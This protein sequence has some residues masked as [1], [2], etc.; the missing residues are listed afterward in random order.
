[1]DVYQLAAILPDPSQVESIS[2]SERK[3]PSFQPLDNPDDYLSTPAIIR[4]ENKPKRTKIEA[5]EQSAIG[6]CISCNCASIVA[7]KTLLGDHKHASSTAETSIFP[8][9]QDQTV[10]Q[11]DQQ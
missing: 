7:K 11:E 10:N 8:T 3:Q 4:V 1:M 2:Y 5:I 9:H 6:I